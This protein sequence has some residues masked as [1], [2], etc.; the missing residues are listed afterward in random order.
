MARCHHPR[1]GADEILLVGLKAQ[2]LPEDLLYLAF[3]LLDRASRFLTYYCEALA[4]LEHA[5][6]LWSAAEGDIGR[7]SGLGVSS[8]GRIDRI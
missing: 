7:P 6:N 5:S 1:E 4:E 3:D 2:L 8:E